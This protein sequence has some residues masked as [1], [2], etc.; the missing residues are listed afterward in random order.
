MRLISIWIAFLFFSS[1]VI[2]Q[3]LITVDRDGF[4]IEFPSNWEEK[5][6]PGNLIYIIES[7]KESEGFI[8]TLGLQI[9]KD[10]QTLAVFCEQYEKELLNN[11]TYKDCKIK[12]KKEFQSGDKKGIYYFCTATMAHLPTELIC[13]AFEHDGKIIMTTA[14]AYW[15]DPS[16]K[17]KDF[18]QLFNKT[19]KILSSIKVE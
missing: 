3:E 6:M 17:T 2:S 4:S 8:T 9:T 7:A 13:T 11:T 16:K 14:T 18:M 12:L 19:Q 5:E 15:R 1:T 10:E